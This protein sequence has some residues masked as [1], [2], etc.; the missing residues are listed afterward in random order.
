MTAPCGRCGALLDP[1]GSCLNGC[2]T[3]PATGI[4]AAYDPGPLPA[5]G[6]D[7]AALLDEVHAA[8]TRYVVFP[9]PESA[10]AVAL[11]TAATHAQPAWEH[12]T[13]LVVK[14]P[15]K[16]CGKT[17]LQEVVSELCYHP[18]RT[19]N[20]SVAALVRSIPEDNPP[21]LILDEADSVFSTRKGER[22]E[23]AED[24]RG[25]LNS[26][27][28]RGW[29]YIR[30]DATARRR[31]EC[32]TFAMALVGGIGDMPDTV[33]DRAVTV[34][35]RRRAPGEQVASFRRRRSIPPLHDLR[36]RLHEWVTAHADELAH[37][38]PDLPVED[39]VADVWEPIAA[40]ADLAGGE[41]PDRARKACQ[42]LAGDDDDLDAGTAG[43]RLLADLQE[44]WGDE[45]YLFTTT[46]LDRLA[47]IEEAPWA[48]WHRGD[49]LSPR[50]L[51]TLLKPYKIKSR[52]VRESPASGTSRG[53]ARADLADAWHRYT[54][55]PDTSDTAT[56]SDETVPPTSANGGVTSVSD[57]LFGSNT[58][59]GQGEQSP[60]VGVSDVLAK[61]LDSADCAVCGEPLDP[62]LI[63]AGY[64]DH[65]ENVASYDEAVK[66]AELGPTPIAEPGANF[67]TAEELSRHMA[68]TFGAD[69]KRSDPKPYTDLRGAPIGDKAQVW[70]CDRLVY[71]RRNSKR[72]VRQHVKILHCAE[73]WHSMSGSTERPMGPELCSTLLEGKWALPSGALDRD[74]FHAFHEEH[75]VVW[76]VEV[77][78]NSSGWRYAYCD[79]E[80]PDEYREL[81]P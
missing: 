13:R 53:Y 69:G 35:M 22:S 23:S 74:R 70:E 79:P 38:E 65:G 1:D 17:R 44:V 42:V 56:R 25:I 2:G 5:D 26:G 64:T 57:D 67:I 19:T 18:L 75:P 14:S 72:R 50:G 58:V 15:L 41:W 51:A 8:L 61:R 59:P 52:T 37:S 78:V 27:H 34:A 68:V 9:S 49:K 29:P 73:G 55:P 12:A 62:A 60:S 11:W 48:A 47:A 4:A 6:A 76:K 28:S 7:G 45:P 30:W 36:D 21:T 40:V 31:E 16:R 43:E 71:P 46:V 32:P 54:R 66:I 39:R 80:L 77:R 20:I 3:A 33:E 63:A 10:D 81:L 24:L